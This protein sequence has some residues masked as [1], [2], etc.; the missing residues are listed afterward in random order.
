MAAGILTVRIAP[1]RRETMEVMLR[2]HVEE[3]RGVLPPRPI[4]ARRCLVWNAKD[5]KY[6]WSHFNIWPVSALLRFMF[7]CASV[8]LSEKNCWVLKCLKYQKRI[9]RIQDTEFGEEKV[10]FETQLRQSPTW[11]AVEMEHIQMI[12]KMFLNNRRTF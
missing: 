8:L 6:F 2:P 1:K 3:H 12:K 5:L 4:T 10:R 11:I 9:S 7:L